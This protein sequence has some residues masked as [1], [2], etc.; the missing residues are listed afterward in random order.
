MES[1]TLTPANELETTAPTM[2]VLLGCW[3]MALAPL[4]TEAPPKQHGAGFSCQERTA[5]MRLLC[6]SIK[7][8]ACAKV[9]RPPPTAA[10]EPEEEPPGKNRS[11]KGF[12]AVP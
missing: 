9:R 12:R 10:P 8:A 1:V 2:Q 4:A 6:T 5:N 11:S 3:S 7:G